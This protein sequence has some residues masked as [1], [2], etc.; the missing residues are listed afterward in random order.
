MPDIED[1]TILTYNKKKALLKKLKIVKGNAYYR[2]GSFSDEII[3]EGRK[4]VFPSPKNNAS[5]NVWVFR[6]VMNNVRD[7]VIDKR[8]REKPQLPVNHWNE[9]LKNYRGK[10]TATD[11]DHAY[12]RIAF[13]QGVIT[14]KTYQRGL[15]LKDKALRLA[16]LA[17][18]ASAKEYRVIENGVLTD[19]TIVVKH[20]PTLRKVYDNIRNTCYQIMMKLAELLGD[21]FICYKTDCIYYKDKK[22]NRDKVHTYLDKIGM[23][24]KQLVEPDR[25]QK[26]KPDGTNL[27]PAEN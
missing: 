15:L 14:D 5:K 16:S 25:P 3:W 9:N 22:E 6:S 20:D 2:E 11:V 1:L 21:D 23:Q 10:I 13:L 12:W 19:K 7:Y 4:F 27:G 17:N 8:I 24:Y 18:L 26:D